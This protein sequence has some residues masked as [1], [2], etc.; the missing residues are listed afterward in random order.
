VGK[1]HHLRGLIG[2]IAEHVTLIASTHVIIA[3][4]NVHTLSNVGAL[5][6]DGDEDVASLVVEANGGISETNPAHGVTDD[7]LVVKRRLGGDFSEDHD[8]ASLARGLAS[9]LGVR[10]LGKA[11]IEN[12]VRDLIAELVRV[13]LRDALRGEEESLAGHCVEVV[14]ERTGGR[15]LFG[16]DQ[17]FWIIPRI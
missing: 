6:L 10:I 7:L 9:D 8:H 16:W 12:S 3:P 17:G 11:S 1:R 13:T 14:V 4:T 15:D 5:L 2:G